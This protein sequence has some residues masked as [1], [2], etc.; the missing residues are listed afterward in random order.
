MI[1]R[2][3]P[4]G[5]G[6]KQMKIIEFPTFRSKLKFDV[7]V[8]FD[9][10]KLAQFFVSHPSILRAKGFVQ[11]ESGWN[12][13]NYSLTGFSFE[14]CLAKIQNELV[15]IAEKSDMH[16]FQNIKGEIENICMPNQ[17]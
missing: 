12:L 9:S 16:P 4:L 17:F 3:S 14:P 10:G 2:C 13:F 8:I 15:V 11:T 5:L 6:V 1:F 7:D